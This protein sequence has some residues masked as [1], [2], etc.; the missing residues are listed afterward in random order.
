MKCKIVF[1][2]LF[3]LLCISHYGYADINS[4][5]ND[6]FGLKMIV[7]ADP[8]GDLKGAYQEGIRI[9]DYIDRDK[10]FINVSLRSGDITPNFIREKIR[11]FDFVHF[12][13]HSDYNQQN[14]GESGWQLTSGTVKA[15]DIIKMAG[16][17]TMPALIFSNA[18]QSART[19]EWT[20]K[21]YFQDE[22]FGF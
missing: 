16:T 19:E 15:Q 8:K 14:P 10:D 5:T 21:E 7:I 11:N 4:V 1:T 13:G 18:C 17:A 3:L 12:A 22:I 20:L 6:M 2:F 9:R